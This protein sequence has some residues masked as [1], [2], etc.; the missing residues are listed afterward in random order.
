[1][2]KLTKKIISRVILYA[3]ILISTF[4]ALEFILNYFNLPYTD[5]DNNRYLL[6]AMA[7]SQAAI[8]AIVITVSLIAVQLAAS[9]YSLRVVNIFKRNPDFWLLLALYGG[10]MS[11]DFFILKILSENTSEF[12]IFISYWL[13]TS[14]VLMLFPYMLSMIN[15]LNPQAT[16]RMLS[17]DIDL[18]S[19]LRF[20]SGYAKKEEGYIGGGGPFSYRYPERDPFQPVVDIILGGF[21]KYDYETVRIGLRMMTTKV[22]RILNSYDFEKDRFIP[23]KRNP[24]NPYKGFAEHYCE[25]INRIGKF[26]AERNEELTL[27]TIENLIAIAEIMTE[28]RLGTEDCVVNSLR[29]IGKLST[30]KE[31]QKATERSLDVIASIVENLPCDLVIVPRE[32]EYRVNEYNYYPCRKSIEQA[33]DAFDAIS[34]LAVRKWG[35]YELQDVGRNL[36]KVGIVIAKGVDKWENVWEIAHVAAIFNRIGIIALNIE[37]NPTQITDIILYEHV[38]QS[39]EDIA[40][41]VHEKKLASREDVLR[42]FKRSVFALWDVGTY[43]AANGCTE[44]EG[45]SAKALA[46]LAVLDEEAVEEELNNLKHREAKIDSLAEFQ[47]FMETYRNHLKELRTLKDGSQNKKQL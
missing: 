19:S 46:E 34:L 30:Q 42:G 29:S 16:I 4:C 17:D 2:R 27:E 44:T 41:I 25:H 37:K 5:I 14:A 1:M 15:A 38:I 10:S 45:K 32:H 21:Q 12:Y 7:Q 26:L 47:E 33:L 8:I 43:A 36:R 40:K 9:T 20:E 18:S 13:C 11:Y 23:G 28:K 3:V 31:F 22:I 6:S 24:Y 35:A 39:L